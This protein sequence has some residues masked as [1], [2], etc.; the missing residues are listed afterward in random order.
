M[1][2]TDGTA[3]TARKARR[4]AERMRRLTELQV[5]EYNERYHPELAD[6]SVEIGGNIIRVHLPAKRVK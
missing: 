4:E 5:R 1:K 2:T 6:A 3:Q